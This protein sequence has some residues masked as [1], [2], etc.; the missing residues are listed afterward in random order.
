M[1][2]YLSIVTQDGDRIDIS[3]TIK[4]R[5]EVGKDRN[6]SL[7]ELVLTYEDETEDR[8]RCGVYLSDL[9]AYYAVQECIRFYNSEQYHTYFFPGYDCQY[10]KTDKDK[11]LET[12]KEDYR[13][14][15]Q[16]AN[17]NAREIKKM[18]EDLNDEN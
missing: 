10:D 16:A 2:D 13:K 3:P 7:V 15:L 4:W 8:Y 5:F 17:Y 1:R 12:E 6:A 18:M 14:A 11:V 9:Y